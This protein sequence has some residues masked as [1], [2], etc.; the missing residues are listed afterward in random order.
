MSKLEQRTVGLLGGGQLGRMLVEAASRLNIRVV[1]L[2]G[3]N[4]PAKQINSDTGHIDGSFANRQDVEELSGCCDLITIEIE[5]VN[6]GA[7]EFASR[8]VPIE[9]SWKSIRL[10]QDKFAQKQHLVKHSIAVAQFE[11]VTETSHEQ[12]ARVGKLFG[13]PFMLKAKTQAYDGKGNFCVG[14]ESS[15]PEALNTL[16]GR[17]LYAER[18]AKFTKELAVMVVKTADGTYAFPTVETVHED[19]I[20]KL[21]Y[22]PA[23]CVSDKTIKAAKN[24]AIRSIA[25]L[26]GKGVFGV[27][28]FLLEDDTLLVNEIAPRPHNSGHYTIE[29][30]GMSQY[31]AHL[32]AILDR[33]LDQRSLQQHVPAIMLNILGGRDTDSHFELVRSA[34]SMSNASIHIYGKGDAKPGRKMGHITVRA[35]TMY[36]AEKTIQP[37]VEV[38][39]KIRASRLDLEWTAPSAPK[40][41]TSPPVAVVAGSISDQGVLKDCYE[42]LEKLDIPFEK[43]ITSAH[44]T[45]ELMA[46]WS[47]LAK[48]NGTKVIIAAAGGAAHLPGMVAAHSVLPIIGVPIKPTIGDGLD[49]VLSILNMPNGVPVATVAVNK[50][51]NAALLAARILG[52]WDERVSMRVSAYAKSLEAESLENDRKLQ[53]GD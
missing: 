43:R 10:I 23:R 44:R 8:R 50:A 42:M 39:D 49:S 13:Y 3:P 29:A 11:D 36:E 34:E 53:N 9:P 16:K 4:A 12:V 41:K 5:H 37:L 19:S 33:P 17:P 14:N 24:L 22:A 6:T 20:C 26:E 38:A 31:E 21:V 25:S 30:C 46:E 1:I 18:W 40:P 32:R 47:K 45:P 27:E 28:M 2:D 7:L 51:R 48:G 15:I 52:S 35:T